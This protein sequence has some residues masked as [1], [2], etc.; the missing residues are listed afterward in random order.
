MK[1]TQDKMHEVKD[2][3]DSKEISDYIKKHY[4]ILD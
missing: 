4:D 1:N 2:W 3:I